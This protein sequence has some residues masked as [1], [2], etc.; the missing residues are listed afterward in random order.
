M[1]KLKVKTGVYTLI[2][3]DKDGNEIEESKEFNFFLDIRT[4]MKMQFIKSV[5]S[6]VVGESYYPVL[7]DMMFD[8]MLINYFTD[9]DVKNILDSNNAVDD[10]EEFLSRTNAVEVIKNNLNQELLDELSQGV[11]FD[12]EY[13]TGVHCNDISTAVKN[14]IHTLENKVSNIDTEGMMDL[15]TKLSGMTGNLT[16]ESIVEAYAKTDNFTGN[17]ASVIEEKNKQ[18][19][20][21]TELLKMKNQSNSKGKK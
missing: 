11:D 1:K 20:E 2:A 7:K 6:L 4:S 3:I 10:I 16:P 13:K 5:V 14:L 12:I 17:Q 9:I 18:I 15:A 8:I 19:V 21:L